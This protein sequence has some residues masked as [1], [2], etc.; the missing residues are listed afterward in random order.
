M[1]LCPFVQG[2]GR[3]V[4]DAQRR[5]SGERGEPGLLLPGIG[6]DRWRGD[7]LPSSPD[8]LPVVDPVAP[9]DDLLRVVTDNVVVDT[10]PAAGADAGA[11]EA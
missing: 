8:D 1:H 2:R 3:P 10:T 4:G 11:L 7:D 5:E 9:E 6:V